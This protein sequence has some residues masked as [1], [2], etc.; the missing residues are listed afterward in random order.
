MKRV[1]GEEVG[2]SVPG[3]RN[4]MCKGHVQRPTALEKVAGMCDK[5]SVVETVK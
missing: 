3:R 5:L 1:P 2:K 4:S